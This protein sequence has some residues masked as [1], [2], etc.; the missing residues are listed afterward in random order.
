VVARAVEELPSSSGHAALESMDE[1]G[2]GRAIMEHQD[3]V[4]VPCAGKLGA[5]LGETR[6]VVA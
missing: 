3:G 2:A 6:D 1:G 4:V 5:A